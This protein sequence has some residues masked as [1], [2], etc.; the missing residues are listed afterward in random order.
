MLDLISVI[1]KGARLR[2]FVYFE[3]EPG[4]RSRRLKGPGHS[5]GTKTIA[6]RFEQ[7]QRIFG[8]RW[9]SDCAPPPAATAGAHHDTCRD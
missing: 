1:A 6:L 7:A 9:L 5:G 2:L 3:E 8:H 4:R